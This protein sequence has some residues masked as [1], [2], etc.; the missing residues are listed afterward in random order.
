MTIPLSPAPR[1]HVAIILLAAGE[2]SRMG[3]PKQL[4]LWQALP[5]VQYQIRQAQLSTARELVVVVGHE[6]A[7]VQPLAQK[8][9][10]PGRGK[11]IVNPDYAEGKTTSIKAG[12]RAAPTATAYI[13]LAVDQPRP[14]A[15][16]QA[17]IDAHLKNRALISVPSYHGKHGHPPMFDASLAKELLASSEEKQGIK[18]VVERHREALQEVPLSDPIVTTNLNTLADY[19]AAKAK[20]G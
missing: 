2:S 8:A 3:Q 19:E 15:V 4:L 14:V 11:V 13:L 5:L 16:L 7:K 1:P 18:E 20:W 17:L 9:V 10:Q 6:L 12:I